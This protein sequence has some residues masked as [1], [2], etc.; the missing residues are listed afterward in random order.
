MVGVSLVLVSDEGTTGYVDRLAVRKDQRNR[1][2]AQALLVDSFA[3]A[4]DHGTTT[5]ELSTDSRTGALGL[6]ER[7]GMTVRQ[8]WVNRASTCPDADNRQSLTV[9]SEESAR[10][11]W[12][13]P[14]FRDFRGL[15]RFGD[16]RRII[17]RRRSGGAT[18]GRGV[19]VSAT[20]VGV[21]NVQDLHA[22]VVED[23]PDISSALVETLEGA[24]FRVTSARDGRAAVDVAAADRPTW[25]RST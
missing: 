23:D 1:G 25:S 7:V 20:A 16:M 11:M 4:R 12:S 5:S 10:T 14:L 19:L 22:L 15:S 6:Y 18:A 9:R 21:V 8:V 3:A 24:G 17:G 13:R 2:L